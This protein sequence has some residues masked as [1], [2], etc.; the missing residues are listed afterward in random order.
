M[1]PSACCTPDVEAFWNNRIKVLIGDP[2]A[3]PPLKGLIPAY[4]EAL[5]ALAS[6]GAQTYQLDTGQS[7]QLVSKLNLTQLRQTREA[8]V[9]ELATIQARLGCGGSTHVVPNW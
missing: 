1:N 4:D 2:N 9:N 8:L 3:A 7:R 5:L 6:G